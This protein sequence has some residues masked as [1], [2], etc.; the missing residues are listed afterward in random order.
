MT[1]LI[2]SLGFSMMLAMPALAQTQSANP[3]KGAYLGVP[4]HKIARPQNVCGQSQSV[5]IKPAK[6]RTSNW[7]Q[8]AHKLARAGAD[9][10]GSL[11]I[12]G[13]LPQTPATE[14]WSI[15]AHQIANKRAVSAVNTDQN[16]LGPLLNKVRLVLKR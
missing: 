12:P 9:S 3:C 6:T 16:V 10:G 4:S 1:K 2:F 8:P 11:V 15:P 5:V 13:I 14:S 7:S